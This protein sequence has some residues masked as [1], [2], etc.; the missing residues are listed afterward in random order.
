MPH[1]WSL[2]GNGNILEV[3][4]HRRTSDCNE[5]SRHRQCILPQHQGRPRRTRDQRLRHERLMSGRRTS[6]LTKW[7]YNTYETIRRFQRRKTMLSPE[8][9]N[10]GRAWDTQVLALQLAII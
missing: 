8:I 9:T 4:L 7:N 5:P 10:R 3:K 2:P 1:G 6:L